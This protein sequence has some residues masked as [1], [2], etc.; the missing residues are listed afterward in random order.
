MCNGL[1][2]LQVFQDIFLHHLAYFLQGIPLCPTWDVPFCWTWLY[3]TICDHG[4][5]TEILRLPVIC[6]IWTKRRLPPLTS[7]PLKKKI[8]DHTLTFKK[9]STRKVA[10]DQWRPNDHRTRHWESSVSSRN[11]RTGHIQPTLTKICQSMSDITS[12]SVNVINGFFFRQKMF[13]Q[14]GVPLDTKTHVMDVHTYI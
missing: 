11:G 8:K 14:F 1:S 7:N 10:T 9:T 12:T 5:H 13:F 2:E 3:Q 6:S 4:M